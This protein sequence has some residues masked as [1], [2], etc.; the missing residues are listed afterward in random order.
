[1]TV[2]FA[3]I[4]FAWSPVQAHQL[5]CTPRAKAPPSLMKH[6]DEGRVGMGLGNN[7]E[8][9]ELFVSP[10]GTF[11][12]LTTSPNGLSCMIQA[13]TIWDDAPPTLSENPETSL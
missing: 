13:G 1:M 6:Y 12:V 11:T 9:V 5:L 8:M 7:G 3:A 4:F 2:A 10:S